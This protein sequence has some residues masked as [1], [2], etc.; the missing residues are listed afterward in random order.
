VVVAVLVD[1]ELATTVLGVV[2]VSVDITGAVVVLVIKASVELPTDWLIAWL[3]VAPVVVAPL[4]LDVEAVEVA[5]I[6]PL[7]VPT[8]VSIA[9]DVLVALSAGDSVTDSSGITASGSERAA[10]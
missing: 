4:S 9:G 8:V 5:I 10:Y 7:L 2:V 6:A 1:D 3:L